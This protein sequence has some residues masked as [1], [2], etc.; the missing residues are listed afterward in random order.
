MPSGAK[1]KKGQIRE[2]FVQGFDSMSSALC[3]LVAT[4]VCCRPTSECS[5]VFFG[6]LDPNTFFGVGCYGSLTHICPKDQSVF[7]LGWP[8]S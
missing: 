8:P 7:A 1:G 3:C 4:W 2:I 6:E 5:L